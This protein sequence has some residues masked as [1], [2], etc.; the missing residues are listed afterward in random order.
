MPEIGLAV[1][2]EMVFCDPP[3]I[4]RGRAV[5]VDD[6]LPARRLIDPDTDGPGRCEPGTAELTGDRERVARHWL[7]RHRRDGGVGVRR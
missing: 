6:R 2:S 4:D 7:C 3:I 5:L 1:C